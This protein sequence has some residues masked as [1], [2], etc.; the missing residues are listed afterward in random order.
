MIV[1]I[2]AVGTELLLGQTVNTNCAYL[3]GRLAELGHDAH[4]QTVVGDNPE[5][6]TEA[7][8]AAAAR[9]DAVLITGGLGPTPDDVTRE[10]VCAAAGLEMAYDRDYAA[11]LAE[12]W[13]RRGMSLPDN[14]LRQAEHPQGARLL[15]NPRGTAPGLVLRCLGALLIVLPGV[16]AE[17]H[18]MFEDHAAAALAEESGESEAL[19]SRMLRTWGRGE[20]AV[21]EMLDD[22]YHAGAN[23]S[24]AYLASAGEVKVRISAKAPDEGSAR[25]MIAPVEAEVRRRLGPSVFAADEQTIEGIILEELT[26]RGWTIGAAES[27]TAGMVAARLSAPPGAS[28]VFRGGVAAYHPQ[29]KTGALGVSAALLEEHGA[30]SAETAR[31]MAEGASR[32]LGTETAV[33]VT[34]S[35][36]PEPLERPPGSA[37]IAVRTPEG[38]R[39][40]TL[41]LPGDRERVRA[42]ATTAALQLTRLAVVGEW[43]RSDG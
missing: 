31:A 30:V 28:A 6:M 27:M 32:L 3:G 35:A 42:Y 26:R 25:T 17:M 15:P 12:R 23:P 39:A 33:A 20:S 13:R 40:K 19:V 38:M 4:Y 24:L 7:I 34:G 11:E 1:E 41:R 5:R 43:W 18:R 16:P 37:V 29:V 14:N 9:A 8:R 21:A 10:A 36:G 22:L 2:V